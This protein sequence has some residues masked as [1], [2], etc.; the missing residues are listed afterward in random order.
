MLGVGRAVRRIIYCLHFGLN[1]Y[2]YPFVTS[3]SLYLMQPGLSGIPIADKTNHTE[4]Y[5]LRKLYYDKVSW[6][7]NK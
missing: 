6:Y 1:A 4:I 5:T 7:T 3:L 2:I